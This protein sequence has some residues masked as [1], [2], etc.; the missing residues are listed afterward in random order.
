MIS[1][2]LS[3]RSV[4]S[5]GSAGP[6]QSRFRSWFQLRQFRQVFSLLITEPDRGASC[7]RLTRAQFAGWWSRS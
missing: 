3:K 6:F 1:R 2:I 7:K 5:V 4:V